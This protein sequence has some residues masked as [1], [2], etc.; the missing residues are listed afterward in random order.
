[1]TRENLF[2]KQSLTPGKPLLLLGK[3]GSGKTYSAV[4]TIKSIGLD[5][6]FVNVST[7][8]YET[9][10]NFNALKLFCKSIPNNSVIIF[11][12]IDH[13]VSEELENIVINEMKNPDRIVVLT[14]VELNNKRILDQ[15][16]NIINFEFPY[17]KFVNWALV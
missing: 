14:A 4:K 11:E 17:E 7:Y 1:M 16:S 8:R 13:I 12:N 5:Y 6:R 9:Y 15:C 3:Y 2:L 10:N